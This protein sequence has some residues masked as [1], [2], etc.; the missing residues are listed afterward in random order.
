M[1]DFAAER[2]LGNICFV[3]RIALTMGGRATGFGRSHLSPMRS[4]NRR[5]LTKGTRRCGSFCSGYPTHREPN[6][7]VKPA[8]LAHQGQAKLCGSCEAGRPPDSRLPT[9]FL[10]TVGCCAC[11]IKVG[12]LRSVGAAIGSPTPP[13]AGRDNLRL[14]HPKAFPLRGRWLAEGETVEVDSSR[15]ERIYPFRTPS[16]RRGDSRIAADGHL[17]SHHLAVATASPQGE[18]FKL[19]QCPGQK[20]P[21]VGGYRPPKS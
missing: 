1:Q 3:P 14:P 6:T 15:R 20:L 17:I 4:P 18:A 9:A 13:P 11:F 2:A 21:P 19:C 16:P 10:A 12:S 8:E 5:V 7:F